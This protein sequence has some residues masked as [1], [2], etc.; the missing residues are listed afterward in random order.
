MTAAPALEDL[1]ESLERIGPSVPT[2]ELVVLFGSAVAG[3]HRRDSDVD[4]GVLCD[5]PA[6]LDALF[7][8]LAP[9]FKSSRLDLVDLRR[10]GPVLAF[11][12]ARRGV[13]LFERT[14]AV[15][16]CFQSLASRRYADTKKLRDAQRRALQLYIERASRA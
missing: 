15:F 1:R 12:V 7:M 16:R 2:L 4:V 10:A 9:V 5:G 8:S 6:D 3:R 11:E 14:P 13:V